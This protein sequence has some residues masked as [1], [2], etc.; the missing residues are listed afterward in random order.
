MAGFKGEIK[1][2]DEIR[3]WQDE[4]MDAVVLKPTLAIELLDWTLIFGFVDH[5]DFYYETYKAGVS[6]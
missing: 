4:T 5:L 6:L 1:W 3:G 2:I